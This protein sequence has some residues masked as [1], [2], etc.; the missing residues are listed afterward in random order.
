MTQQLHSWAFIPEKR[1]FF[2]HKNLCTNVYDSF[3]YNSQSVGTGQMFFN[4]KAAETR[5][6][7]GQLL[8]PRNEGTTR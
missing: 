5:P 3:S 2:S 8:S 4:N 6:D 1:T 7:H